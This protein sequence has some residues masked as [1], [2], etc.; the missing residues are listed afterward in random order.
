M[1]CW[2]ITAILNVAIQVSYSVGWIAPVSQKRLTPIGYLLDCAM[3]WRSFPLSEWCA[4]CCVLWWILSVDG[5]YN[6]I[7]TWRST[8]NLR[9]CMGEIKGLTW[10]DCSIIA[11]KRTTFNGQWNE[12]SCYLLY[13][14][15]LE[16]C[17]VVFIFAYC[18]ACYHVYKSWFSLRCYCY[19]IFPNDCVFS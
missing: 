13:F 17:L 19:I 16:F 4:F 7:C 15:P 9:L 14:S 5:L 3:W 18:L 1:L 12:R 2:A 11:V 6:W 10:Y 8:L